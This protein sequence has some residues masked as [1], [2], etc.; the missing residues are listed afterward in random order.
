MVVV[1]VV[2]AAKVLVVVVMLARN[3]WRYYCYW[4]HRCEAAAV[5]ADIVAVSQ[6]CCFVFSAGDDADAVDIAVPMGAV[7]A[8]PAI[9][10]NALL[11]KGKIAGPSLSR[12][13]AS[14]FALC[15]GFALPG[16]VA[17]HRS[18]GVSCIII[19]EQD[20]QDQA[21]MSKNIRNM[22]FGTPRNAKLQ[23][24]L[25]RCE[26]GRRARAFLSLSVF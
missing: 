10:A 12:L 11:S 24:E 3:Y 17:V 4:C 26:L 22:P 2:V 23:T 25:N 15:V 5:V 7:V 8:D 9:A 18:L 6:N 20:E 19:V 21:N 1:V 16:S 14:L 13:C